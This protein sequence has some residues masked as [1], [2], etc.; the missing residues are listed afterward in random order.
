MTVGDIIKSLVMAEDY[1]EARMKVSDE[2]I[3]MAKVMLGDYEYIREK[4]EKYQELLK[5]LEDIKL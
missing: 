1:N 4:E 3:N 5:M 2:F